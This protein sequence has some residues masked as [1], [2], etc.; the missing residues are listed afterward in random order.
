M[1]EHGGDRRQ[2]DESRAVEPHSPD[3]S[4]SDERIE[5]AAADADKCKRWLYALVPLLPG[6]GGGGTENGGLRVH[7]AFPCIIGL[8]SSGLPHSTNPLPK[9]SSLAFPRARALPARRRGLTRTFCLLGGMVR[10]PR[11]CDIVLPSE[12][13]TVRPGVNCSRLVDAVTHR[14]P[15]KGGL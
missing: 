15:P 6:E 8:F 10:Q 4:C 5:L 11:V 7:R 1:R 9:M 3:T 13:T 14:F 2:I 12:A